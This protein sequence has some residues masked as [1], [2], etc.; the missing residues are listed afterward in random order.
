MLEPPKLR[1]GCRVM[2][3][4]TKILWALVGC[5]VLASGGY[6]AYRLTQTRR[7]ARAQASSNAPSNPSRP[8]SNG[9]DASRPATVSQPAEDIPSGAS[10]ATVANRTAASPI[11]WLNIAAAS[12]GG[13]VEHATSVAT[14]YGRSANQL[15]DG[16]VADQSC[17]P[18]CSWWSADKA[19]FPQ[20]IVLSFYKQR[21]ALIGRVVID[22][23]TSSSAGTSG[24][25]SPRQVEIWVSSSSATDGFNR[26]A[27]LELPPESDA[28][29]IDFSP[30]G[31]RYVRVR[32]A[33][34]HK[35]SRV[36]VGEIAVF[37]NA[38]QQPS[39]LADLPPNLALPALGGGIVY[40][41]SD[42]A[43]YG[44]A[45]LIDGDPAREWRSANAY[46]PQEFVFAFR[47]TRVAFVDHIVLNTPAHL[48]GPKEISVAVSLQSP[49]DGFEDVG[50]LVLKHEAGAQS[51]PIRRRAR[52]VR[53]RL[54][55]AYAA[56][57]YS[58]IGEVQLIEGSAPDYESII[59]T[60]RKSDQPFEAADAS[61]HADL[62]AGA[63]ETAPNDSPAQAGRLELGASVRGTIDPIGESDYYKV[64]VPGPDRSVLTF[65]VA[66]LPHV[67]TSVSLLDAA[68]TVVK[69]FDPSRAAPGSVTF[70]W[71]VNP[72]EYSVQVTEP[73][74]SVVVIW[75]TSGSM[76][77][78][79]A[80]LQ[81]AVEAYL[82]QV[83]PTERVNLIR[84][85][86][87]GWR[88]SRPDIEVLLPEFT[89][90]RNRLKKAAQGKFEADGG[91]PFYD[92]VAKAASLLE[93]STGN[94]LII[95]M[96]DGEDV[97]SKLTQQDFWRL[98]QAKGI[99]LYT[100][101]L[102]DV[103]RY[104]R[105][106]A[107]A[108]QQLLQNAAIATNGRS[109]FTT[110]SG[111]LLKFYQQISDELRTPASYRLRITRAAASGLLDVRA[112]GEH[113]A[114]V[115]APA[116][117]E[118]ILDASGSMNRRN[119]GQRMIDSAKAVMTD[120]VQSLPDDVQVAL[121]VYGHRIREGRP[122]ACE[123]SELAFPFAK[124]DKPRLIARI[125]GIQA[126]GTTPIAFSLQQIA[127][128]VGQ[129]PGEKMIVLVTDGKEECG[130]DPT[131]A[132]KA[133]V[134]QGV[135]VRL[136][137][138]GFAL[139]DA[140][141][142]QDLRR[143]AEL[144]AGQFVD[145]QDASSLRSAIERSLALPYDVLDATGTKIATGISSQHPTELPEGVFTVRVGAEKPIEVT[146]VRIAAKQTTAVELK[147]EGREVGVN[148]VQ[149][150]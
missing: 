90:D 31:A 40:F 126:L 20:D 68:G 123:D 65:D 35:G 61:T 98:I 71:L 101:G 64:G 14:E 111:D 22:T 139:A 75:D 89:G 88:L 30:V 128:D 112:T 32:I 56:N 144:T 102:G 140:A 145:A 93:N 100:I 150:R 76:V 134:S 50:R 36:V 29:V 106:L 130:G 57:I 1:R 119:G 79:T 34:V 110:N 28:H 16:G 23:R 42:Y 92:V 45:Q 9:G 81:R 72:G 41:S 60:N 131:A 59:F 83:L 55:D 132:V 146:G 121:R 53:L 24:D 80:A 109:F 137:V 96:T 46:L 129:A 17:A 51:F 135:K 48:P 141:L 78:D 63:L 147:K 125:R 113:I 18:Y 120:I 133:L 11:G 143:L 91:T 19:T 15:I 85:S 33:S 138:V 43:S 108:P 26:V 118:L 117:I 149:P 142:K 86:S 70:S 3:T 124:L 49:T 105:R 116:Q 37:E 114:S 73:Q 13:R 54:L 69:R 77:R 5:A 62:T 25:N 99:R 94:R 82:D 8:Q 74:A 104:S 4:A 107:A 7:A 12:L 103:G 148:V 21:E 27:A 115:A 122:H 10:P 67:R 39:I 84:F 95:V 52:F 44:A 127:R 66:G 58:A 47:D 6:F 38:G 2:R 97:G 136:N 87:E